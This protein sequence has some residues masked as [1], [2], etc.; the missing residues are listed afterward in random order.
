[1]RRLL[2]V[3]ML[4]IFLITPAAAGDSGRYL[5]EKK[6]F[7]ESPEESEVM[8][9]HTSLGY[10]TVLAFPERPVMVSAGDSSLVQVEIPQ[11]SKN[12]LIKPLYPEG[13][14]NLFIFTS[15][16]RFNYHVLIG[17]REETDYVVDVAEQYQQMQTTP[18]R[19]IAI[20]DL[21]KIVRNYNAHKMMGAVT[22]KFLFQKDIFIQSERDGIKVRLLEAF[23]WKTP[24]YIVLHFD[25]LNHSGLRIKLKEET[26]SVYIQG[27]RFT[28]DY[29]IFDTNDIGTGE[30][31]HGWIVLKNT[32]L[33][34]DNPFA[35]GLNMG[36]NEYV[37]D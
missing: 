17:G 14:T 3:S 34:V 21:L 5:P 37:F 15:N 2:V 31:T 6:V 36:G 29:V 27:R 18:K 22:P 10:S 35:I 24:H 26:T 32:F 28:P 4:G 12:V 13:E 19:D 9:V 11:N 33:S 1:M 8:V 7:Y 25:I 16:Q 30:K 23:T 20:Q